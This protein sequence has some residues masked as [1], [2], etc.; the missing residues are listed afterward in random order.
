MW[1]RRALLGLSLAAAFKQPF[2]AAPRTTEQPPNLN[3][4][5]PNLPVPK[6]D[7]GARHLAGMAMPDLALPSTATRLVNLSKIAAPRV[8]VYCYPMTG[9]PDK[10]LPAG[11][12]DIPG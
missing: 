11:W 4:L 1:S 6:D 7:G 12:D 10:P 9:R 2:V 8:V 3:A 5:P